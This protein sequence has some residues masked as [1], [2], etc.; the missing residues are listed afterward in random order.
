MADPATPEAQQLET[1][2][3]T[4]DIVH[5]ASVLHSWAWDDMLRVAKRLVSLTRAVPGS[6]IIGNQMGSLNPGEYPM[7]T[8]KGCNYRHDVASMEKFWRQVGEETGSQWKVE[9]GLFLPAA[10]RENQEQSWAK[11][12]P[13]LRM[14]WFMATRA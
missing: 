12:D 1:I 8:G 5:V 4:M 3:G 6:M 14:I 13:G 11:S 2:T 7:P 10:V 9:S